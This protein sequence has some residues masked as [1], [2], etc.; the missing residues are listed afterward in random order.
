M[1][2]LAYTLKKVVSV[3]VYP[4]GFSLLLWLMGMVLWLAGKKNKICFAFFA[5]SGAILLI[6]SLPITSFNLFRNLESKAGTYADPSELS[7]LDVRYVVVLGGDVRAGSL[8][9]ADRIASTSLIRTLEGIR[10]WKRIPGAKLVFSGGS[11]SPGVITTAEGMAAFAHEMGIPGD[12]IILES[13]SLDTEE[14]AR[15]L[16]PLLE[17]QKFAL[18]TSAS[19]MNRALVNFRRVGLDPIPAP[20]DFQGKTFVP[21]VARLFPRA[22]ALAECNTA[23]HEY[24]GMLFLWLKD[25]GNLGTPKTIYSDIQSNR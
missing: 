24:L 23:I 4:V 8:T 19:H 21:T 16:K 6:M 14:E 3:F 11:D 18:V 1:D 7:R 12:A 25:G 17:N 2:F 22:N 13:R 10:L 9:P 15:L 20:C 5:G